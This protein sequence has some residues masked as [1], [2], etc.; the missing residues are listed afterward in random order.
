MLT[1]DSMQPWKS[2]QKIVFRFLF[3]FLGFFLLNYEAVFI[4][5]SF[6]FFSRFLKIYSSLAQPLYWLDKH[7]YHRGYNLQLHRSFPGDNHFGIVF[8]FTAVLLIIL[9]VTVWSILDR[10]RTQ[11]NK[12]YYWFRLYVRYMVALIMFGYGIDKLIPVQM[13]YPGVTELLTP[14]GEQ[15]L[16]STVWNFVGASPGYE[17]FI[18]ACEVIGSLLLI[19][20]RTYVFGS[21]FMCTILC[22]VVALNIFYNIPVKLYSSLLLICVLFLIAPYIHKLIQF[23]FYDR[24]ISLTEKHYKFE[25]SWKKYIVIALGIGI[26]AFGFFSSIFWANKRYRDHGVNAKREK[27]FDVTYFITKDTLQPLLTDTLRWRKFAFANKNSAV[28]YNMQDKA[29]YYVCDEDTMK[30]TY[31]LHDNP[32]TAS[33]QVFHYSYPEKNMLQLTGKWKE[34]DVNIILKEIPIDSMALP[35]EKLI[36]F[37]E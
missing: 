28:I 29:G 12:L 9:V 11:Y 30:H 22:N 4:S 6:N 36:F 31:T 26:P 7:L 15:N 27:L 14:F 16:F 1:V 34:N 3:L 37:R 13:S 2:W 17:I 10:H 21:L 20:R 8:Y 24:V 25:R 35:K 23:F 18:G 5:F 32:D 19:F 33:W